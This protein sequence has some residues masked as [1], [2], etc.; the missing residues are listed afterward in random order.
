MFENQGYM[1]GA[2]DSY[3]MSGNVNGESIVCLYFVFNRANNSRISSVWS[4][5]KYIMAHCASCRVAI[6]YSFF[7]A[8][9][10]STSGSTT[11]L[12][13]EEEEERSCMMIYDMI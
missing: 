12:F 7:S 4:S 5:I 10:L 13:L 9:N 2:Q 11:V 8:A 1:V 3:A 6:L